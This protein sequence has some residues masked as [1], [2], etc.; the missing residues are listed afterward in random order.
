MS[1]LKRLLNG[2]WRARYRDASGKEHCSHQKTKAEAQQWIDNAGADISRGEWLDPAKQKVTVGEWATR[3]L[4]AV[5]DLEPATVFW[6]RAKLRN[7]VLP[8]FGKRPVGSIDTL[9]VSS[10]SPS[11]TLKGREHGPSTARW[12][13]CRRYWGAAIDGG[14][15]RANPARGVS[16]PRTP[17]RAMVFLDATE[18]ERLAQTIR[19]PT[20]PRPEAR[21]CARDWRGHS[22]EVRR[23]EGRGD[24]RCRRFDSAH[25]VS[26]ASRTRTSSRTTWR[27]TIRA[28]RPRCVRTPTSRHRAHRPA[29]EP[30]E[31]FNR[32]TVA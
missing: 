9:A 26:C 11:C 31:R 8:A 13:P 32:I 10:G 22:V 27:A 16:T 5:V 18:V 6:Y 28:R 14:A 24:A 20:V 3:W 21:R 1:S 17:K 4:D 19:R 12:S 25:S 15:L 23:S 29:D 2:K 30:V 7:H